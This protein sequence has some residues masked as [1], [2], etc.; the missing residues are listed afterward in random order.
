MGVVM[1]PLAPP[2]GFVETSIYKRVKSAVDYTLTVKYPSVIRGPAGLGKTTALNKL[3]WNDPNAVLISASGMQKHLLQMMRLIADAM[4]IH[5]FGRTSYEV[6]SAITT[7]IRE[8]ASE[9]TYLFIDEAHRMNLDTLREI[10]DLWE[11]YGLP[12]ILCGNNEVA[13]KTRTR[14]STFDQISSRIGKEVSLTVMEPHDFVLFG[15]ERGVEGI[16][17]FDALTSYGMRTSMRE[18]AQ[19]LDAARLIVGGSG[20]I[21]VGQIKAAAEYS[22]GSKKARQMLSPD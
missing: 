18:A 17:A 5:V 9:G 8:R 12:I 13:K 6:Y 21:K 10:F 19:L 3:H 7:G 11:N 4:N 2:K 15:I 22:F 1:K 16:E 20:S 14:A